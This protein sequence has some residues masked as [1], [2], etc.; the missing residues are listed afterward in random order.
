[1][2]RP[3]KPVYT[4]VPEKNIYKKKIKDIDGKYIT[5]YE[6][7]PAALTAKIKEAER[8][9]EA[10]AYCRANPTWTQYAARYADLNFGAIN[11]RTK[12]DYDY[13]IDHHIT[14]IIGHLHMQDI[15]TDDCKAVLARLT[16]MSES[17]YGKAVWLMKSV[18]ESAADVDIITKNPARKLKRGGIK[19][20][21]KDALTPEQQ[22]TLID[23]VKG[24]VAESFV[25]IGLHT[26]MRREEL[27]GLKWDCVH[28]SGKSPYV[29]VRRALNWDHNQPQLSENLKSHAAYRDIPIPPI[30]VDFLKEEKARSNSLFVIH[31]SDGGA[32]TQT[33]FK[34]L[35]AAVE[36]RSVGVR[37]YKDK[38]TGRIIETEKKLGDKI[39]RHKA[40]ITIGFD[41]TPHLLRHTYISHLILAGVSIKK[42]QYLAGH[43]DPEMT[44]R[45]YTHLMNNRPADLI[46]DIRRAYR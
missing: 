22:Q 34:N 35:W 41:V 16:R 6:K 13:I 23:A 31:N 9:I 33:Q 10:A 28:L 19:A 20:E 27:L 24:T 17:V 14:P 21:E 42:V 11:P 15:T 46:G 39:P 3:K 30:L 8:Q 45:V 43:S 36:A 7:T 37:R 18:F 1:M 12:A 25:T 4:Y 40:Y 44:L 26:G 5:L 32:K 29:K 38:S 2:A